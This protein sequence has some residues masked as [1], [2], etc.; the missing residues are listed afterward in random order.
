MNQIIKVK[1][2]KLVKVFKYYKKENANRL[3]EL[4]QKT[5]FKKMEKIYMNYLIKTYFIAR[6]Q[7][8]TLN[9]VLR[10]MPI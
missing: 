1:M 6:F 7:K 9:I 5:Q 8:M 10:Q 4:V 2:M 3:R